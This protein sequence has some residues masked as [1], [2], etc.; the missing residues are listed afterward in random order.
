MPATSLKQL[1]Q[2]KNGFNNKV[3]KTCKQHH[4]ENEDIWLVG[5]V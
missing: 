3:T 2:M 1:V 5:D 4:N